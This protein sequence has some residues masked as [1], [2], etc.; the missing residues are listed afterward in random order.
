LLA[1]KPGEHIRNQALQHGR[2]LRK[3]NVDEIKPPFSDTQE[4]VLNTLD[5]AP[6]DAGNHVNS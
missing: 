6:E 2:S 3:L 5:K 1:L 4:E